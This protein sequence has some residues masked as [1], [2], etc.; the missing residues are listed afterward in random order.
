MNIEE[1]GFD[2]VAINYWLNILENAIENKKNFALFLTEIYVRLKEK[3]WLFVEEETRE[4]YE[5]L[6]HKVTFNTSFLH[7]KEGLTRNYL[8]MMVTTR[9]AKKVEI[10][11]PKFAY[12]YEATLPTYHLI[13]RLLPKIKERLEKEHKIHLFEFAVW[14]PEQQSKNL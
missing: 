10:R 6:F 2:K 1:W 5:A 9:L 14:E 13:Q 11:N 12:V 4:E 3:K 7:V 8:M